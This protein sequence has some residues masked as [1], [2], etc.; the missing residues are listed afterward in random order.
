MKVEISDHLI[1]SLIE[2]EKA[3]TDLQ[4]QIKERNIKHNYQKEL[5]END[6]KLKDCNYN[7]VM[8]SMKNHSIL[9]AIGKEIIDGR[10][11]NAIKGNV[12]ASEEAMGETQ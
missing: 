2:S 4:A 10:S 1:N 7:L 8:L 3:I 11:G 9:Q 5:M 6:D 12:N